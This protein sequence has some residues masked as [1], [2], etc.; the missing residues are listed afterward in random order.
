MTLDTRQPRAAAACKLAWNADR[1][2]HSWH[3]HW[4]CT[5]ASCE[6]SQCQGFRA[7]GHPTAAHAR[8]AAASERRDQRIHA[9][10]A[11]H[12]AVILS[13]GVAPTSAPPSR[14]SIVAIADVIAAHRGQ[15]IGCSSGL[16]WFWTLEHV[17]EELVRA[18]LTTPGAPR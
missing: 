12:E 15:G 13:L 8:V 3:F 6:S 10:A 16:V 11:E 14:D 4:S 5:D 18:G 9:A 1:Q 7:A 17:A 2:E